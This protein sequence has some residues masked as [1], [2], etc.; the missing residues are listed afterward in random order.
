MKYIEASQVSIDEKIYLKKDWFGWRVVHPIRNDDGSINWFNLILGSKANVAF[1]IIILLIG[2]VFYLGV[3]DLLSAY[4]EVADN[5][6]AFCETCQMQV[7][8]ILNSINNP[9]AN[10]SKINLT[11]LG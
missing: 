10:T 2:F 9:T 4:K 1:L 11:S 8:N 5:P 7:K 3:T 6:C